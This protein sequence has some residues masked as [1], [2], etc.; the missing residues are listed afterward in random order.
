MNLTFHYPPELMQLLIDTIPLLCRSKKDV[1]LFFKGAGVPDSFTGDLWEQVRKDKASINKY[2]IVRAVLT[3]LNE[4]GE[5]ALRE[6]REVLKRVIEFD[7]FSTCWE[8]DRLKAQGLVSQI[9]KLVNVKDSFTRM[10]EERD[11][12]RSENIANREAEIATLQKQKATLDTIKQ[13]LFALFAETNPQKRG[14]SLE[15]ILNRLFEAHGILVREAF[16]LCGDSGE[17]IVEQIDGVVEISGNHYLVEMKWWNKPLGV[18]EVSQHLV[19]VYHRGQSRGIL[20]SASGFTEPAVT[21]CK[22][23]LK[24]SVFVLCKLEE[25]VH[26]LERNVDLTEF[27]KAKIDAAFTHKNPFHDPIAAGELG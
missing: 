2:E 25:L 4:R 7:D 5:P 20:I 13:E 12:E 18:G 22:D 3:R 14:K 19:R 17:G 16:T 11:R 8:N 23:G 21:T 6:R 24:H 9:Q 15:G 10:K 1:L 26:L 27:F